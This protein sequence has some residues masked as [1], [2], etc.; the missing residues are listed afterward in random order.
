MEKEN[1]DL[2]EGVFDSSKDE[3]LEREARMSLGYK[4]E[5]ETAVILSGTTT[6]KSQNEETKSNDF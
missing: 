6:T 5:G 4:K 1:T 3:Y 2:K